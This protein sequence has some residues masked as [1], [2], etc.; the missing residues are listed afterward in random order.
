MR[1]T[2]GT[3][4]LQKAASMTLVAGGLRGSLPQGGCLEEVVFEK[5]VSKALS[6]GSSRAQTTQTK[7]PH[8][9]VMLVCFLV[10]VRAENV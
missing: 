7:M 2:S 10:L 8:I 6:S 1:G 5:A 4:F 9:A 3:S